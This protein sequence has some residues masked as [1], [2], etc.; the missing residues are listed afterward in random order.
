MSKRNLRLLIPMLSLAV[1][2]LAPAGARA[3]DDPDHPIDPPR[4]ELMWDG[5]QIRAERPLGERVDDTGTTSGDTS[6]L[7]DLIILA[8]EVIL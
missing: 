8:T 3:T 1:A 6:L 2:L 4:D 5:Y 7:T